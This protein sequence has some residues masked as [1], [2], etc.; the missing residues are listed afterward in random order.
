MI[1]ND[2]V[3]HAIKHP[4]TCSECNYKMQADYKALASIKGGKVRKVVC[5]EA[6]RLE[7]D[8]RIWQQIA[9]RNAKKRGRS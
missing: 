6:C 9:S 8:S 4:R 3:P 7:F 5:S 2:F 1:G